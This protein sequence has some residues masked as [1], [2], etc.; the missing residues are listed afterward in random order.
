M[1]F[2][3]SIYYKQQH[4]N[5]GFA[6]I[7]TRAHART[8]THTQWRERERERGGGEGEREGG[9]AR[10][11]RRGGVGH[12]VKD[13]SDSEKGNPL[14]PHGLLFPISRKGNYISCVISVTQTSSIACLMVS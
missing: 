11:R 2:L 10:E 8:H 7:Y 4:T 13:N 1:H 12:I 6:D 14:P 5:K 9:K 3:N